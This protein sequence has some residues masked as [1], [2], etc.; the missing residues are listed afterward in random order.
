MMIFALGI[1]HPLDMAVERFH[2]GDARQHRVAAAA[3]QHQDLDRRLPFGKS[4]RPVM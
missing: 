2:D 3:A 4:G 1:Q